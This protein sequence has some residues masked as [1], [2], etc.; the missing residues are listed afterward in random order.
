MFGTVKLTE[1][2]DQRKFSYNGQEIFDGKGMWSYSNNFVRNVVIFGVN[3]TSSSHIDN[4][5][6]NI[7]VSGEGKNGLH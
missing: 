7:L 5:K 4:L 6:N 1:K 3:N 2:A